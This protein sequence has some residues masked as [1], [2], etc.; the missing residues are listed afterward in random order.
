MSTGFSLVYR[1]KEDSA[2]MHIENICGSNLGSLSLLKDWILVRRRLITI[3][4]VDRPCSVTL[5]YTKPLISDLL[6][7]G[8]FLTHL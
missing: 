3:L 6:L 5:V 4:G 1:N 8:F 7:E 2:Y